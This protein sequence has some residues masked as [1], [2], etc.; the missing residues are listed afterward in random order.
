[1]AILTDGNPASSTES[2]D[3]ALQVRTQM[4]PRCA[5]GLPIS[6]LLSRATGPHAAGGARGAAD[7]RE[8]AG[9]A[10]RTLANR[11][12]WGLEGHRTAARHRGDA[13]GAHCLPR[14]AAATCGARQY[15]RRRGAG[16]GPATD[17]RR[18]TPS[19]SAG[20][21]YG[22]A[23]GEDDACRHCHDVRQR[24]PQP[25]PSHTHTSQHTAPGACLR[26]ASAG[27]RAPSTTA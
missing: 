11:G 8:D 21:S 20:R 18:S 14:P 17:A 22:R 19:V 26:R 3:E 9:D 5:C 4:T 23:A 6:L 15:G 12:G 24:A 1:M 2:L 27:G 13:S 10:Q 7:V 16:V 25:P